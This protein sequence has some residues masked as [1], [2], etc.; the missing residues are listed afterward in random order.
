MSPFCTFWENGTSTACEKSRRGLKKCNANFSK[1]A[2]G[3]FGHFSVLR[4]FG[5]K[6]ASVGPFGLIFGLS[7]NLDLN[8][9]Q[10]KIKVHIFEV[11]AKM[12]N[13]WPKYAKSHLGAR[14]C[15]FR[16]VNNWRF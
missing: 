4:F 16:S 10:N 15:R 12:S 2:F 7:L 9:G 6:M 5:H 11:M 8:D 3:R 13:I 1:S 14:T